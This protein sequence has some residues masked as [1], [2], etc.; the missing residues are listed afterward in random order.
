M[1]MHPERWS[2]VRSL[3]LSAAIAAAFV[4]APAEAQDV[5]WGKKDAKV[6][7]RAPKPGATK[8]AAPKQG[9]KPPAKAP[10]TAPKAE[11]PKQAPGDAADAR[12]RMKAKPFPADA[13]VPTKADELR[14]QQN[15]PSAVPAP[16][17]LAALRAALEPYGSWHEDPERGLVWVPDEKE[18]GKDFAPYKTEGRWGLDKDGDWTWISN[19]D[20]GDIPFHFGNWTWI[21]PAPEAP[22]AP[23]APAQPGTPILPAAPSGWAWVPG[24]I[25]APA[26]VVWRLGDAK[27]PFVGWAPMPPAH[28][29]SKG[30]S[31]PAGGEQILPFFYAPAQ[32]LFNEQVARHVVSDR[33]LGRA[34]HDGSNVFSG[35]LGSC[36]PDNKQSACDPR[37]L[38]RELWQPASPTLKQA[39]ISAA[40]IAEAAPTPRRLMDAVR[41]LRGDRKTKGN[42][43]DQPKPDKPPKKAKMEL[44]DEVRAPRHAKRAHASRAGDGQTM[45]RCVR[46]QRHGLRCWTY[47]SPPLWRGRR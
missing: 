40:L 9:V 32:K 19:Y 35:S 43:Q 29:L 28:A 33:K 8:P 7:R 47:R 12:T 46:T 13:P 10:A 6:K 45:R 22:K 16:N 11:A 34:V 14:E 24:S 27:H 31:A 30:K 17:E 20:W 18:V 39:G 37:Q 15:K 44:S 1:S 38:L 3:V 5:P 21:P 42:I 23:G 36:S 25:F 26:W 2:S 4:A 41:A